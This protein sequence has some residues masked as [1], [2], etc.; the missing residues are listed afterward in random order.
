MLL[1]LALALAGPPDEP[2]G[3]PE[4]GAVLA[5][6]GGCASCHTLD[7][8]EVPFGGGYAVVT[9]F[10]TFYGSNLTPDPEHGLGRWTFDDFRRAMHQGR[11]PDGKAYWPAFPYP[12]FTGMT[13]QDLADLW[14]FLQQQ[15][16]VDRPDQAHEIGGRWRLGFWRML[17]FHQGPRPVPDDPVLARGAYLVNHVGHCGECHTPRTSIGR[18]QWRHHD[19]EGTDVGPHPGPSLTEGLA[20][21]SDSDVDTFFSM[22]MFPDGDFAGGGMGT[23]VFEGTAKLSPEDRAAII[24]WLRQVAEE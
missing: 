4:H 23:I 5:G 22:G 12:S 24:A 10:G 3:D 17:A 16:P 20:A 14:A 15:Q 7:D 13:D 18:L 6:L 19:L 9:D 1:A 21:W 11:G 8:D 2:V